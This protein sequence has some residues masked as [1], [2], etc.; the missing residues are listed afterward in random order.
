M[1]RI[2]LAL[3]LSLCF[4]C[5][6]SNKEAKEE[7]TEYAEYTPPDKKE[8]QPKEIVN[9]WEGV[10]DE[11]ME[12]VADIEKITEEEFFSMSL[13]EYKAFVK[14]YSPNFRDAYRVNHDIFSPSDWEQLRYIMAY[15]L[16]GT[17]G[18]R[19]HIVDF[20]SQASPSPSS[21]TEVVE[22]KEEA[23]EEEEPSI[24][25]T[26]AS[27]LDLSV[28]T[29][30]EIEEALDEMGGMSDQEFYQMFKDAFPEGDYSYLTTD[31][32][33]MLKM[34]LIELFYEEY[35]NRR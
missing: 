7:P 29:T 18:Y 12:E 2:T 1:K 13:N 32:V 28:L 11:L 34:T 5:G 10:T 15:Q 6:C 20:E 16:F 17:T 3:L 9:D 33:H 23:K 27:S 31:D 8:E 19:G 24:K 25:E 26:I 21:S 35:S 30:D 4:L 22:V 14:T